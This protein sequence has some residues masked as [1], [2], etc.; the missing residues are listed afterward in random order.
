MSAQL[1]PASGFTV[2]LFDSIQNAEVR[3]VK[4][5]W[6]DI[7]DDLRQNMHACVA[8]LEMRANTHKISLSYPDGEAIHHTEKRTIDGTEVTVRVTKVEHFAQQLKTFAD[9][10]T[11]AKDATDTQRKAF[12]YPYGVSASWEISG[13]VIRFRLVK[14]KP[15]KDDAPVTVSQTAPVAATPGILPTATTRVS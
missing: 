4:S 10:E 7:P 6:T 11:P 3:E 8:H 1:S 5:W 2:T 15:P 13:P 14:S 9:Q 12:A